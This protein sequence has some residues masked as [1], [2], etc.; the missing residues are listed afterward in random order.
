ML[1]VL[2]HVLRKSEILSQNT[3]TDKKNLYNLY[4]SFL[5]KEV[6]TFYKT[7]SFLGSQV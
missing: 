7:H 1:Q 5:W 6:M 2:E 4:F 3:N